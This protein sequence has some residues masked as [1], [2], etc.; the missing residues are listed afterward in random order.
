M[1]EIKIVYLD[2]TFNF[3]YYSYYYYTNT[4]IRNGCYTSQML[5]FI[6]AVIIWIILEIEGCI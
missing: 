3:Q 6:S 2:A 1:K 5:V 4:N